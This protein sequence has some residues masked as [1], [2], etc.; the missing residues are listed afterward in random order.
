MGEVVGT[1]KKA[2]AML[3]GML[4]YPQGRLSTDVEPLGMTMARNVRSDGCVR[5]SSLR[6]AGFSASWDVMGIRGNFPILIGSGWVLGAVHR[7]CSMVDLSIINIQYS[8]FTN[9]SLYLL[10]FIYV[11][12]VD[13][14]SKEV[15]ELLGGHAGFPPR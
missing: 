4:G 10:I 9:S 5:Q 6:A 13:G 8:R 15:K 7:L 3:K 12:E 1:S 11:G 2:Y 14:T